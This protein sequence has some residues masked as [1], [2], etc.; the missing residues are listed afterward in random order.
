MKGIIAV[1][2]GW[3]FARFAL[4]GPIE[5]NGFI[6]GDLGCCPECIAE[7]SKVSRRQTSTWYCAECGTEGTP[8]IS[9]DLVCDQCDQL[10]T[11]AVDGNGD[12]VS[13]AGEFIM[14]ERAERQQELNR[15]L[16]GRLPVQAL[17]RNS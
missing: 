12:F 11:L 3:C 1:E 13:D 7:V 14:M 9:G 4:T 8:D 2:C 10:V 5:Y 16:S 15:L 6:A 17:E